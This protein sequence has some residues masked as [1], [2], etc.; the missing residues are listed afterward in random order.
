MNA[1][2]LEGITDNVND[3]FDLPFTGREED[4]ADQ[5]AAVMLLSPG[6]DGKADPNGVKVA[7]DFARMWQLYA[8]E[9]PDPKDFLFY[10]EHSFDQQRMYNFQCWIYGA[11]PASN[12]AIVA[13]G[14]LPEERADR[15]E[16]EWKKL[17]QAWNQML[18]PHMKV[19][20]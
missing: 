11:D 5:L 17:S 19:A 1:R 2:Y 18:L 3:I 14:D 10:D 8:A 15:C 12:G 6:A 16:G 7:T 13:D 9:G 4:V 20:S